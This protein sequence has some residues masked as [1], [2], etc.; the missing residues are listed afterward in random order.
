[1][2]LQVFNL[3]KKYKIFK[4]NRKFVLPSWK[5]VDNVELPFQELENLKVKFGSLFFEVLIDLRVK[6]NL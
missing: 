5:Q 4:N 3:E 6:S 2:D 1:M